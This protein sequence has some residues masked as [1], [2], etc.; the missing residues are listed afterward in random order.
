[1]PPFLYNGENMLSESEFKK[2]GTVVE[3]L[4]FVKDMHERNIMIKCIFDDDDDFKLHE[5]NSYLLIGYSGTIVSWDSVRPNNFESGFTVEVEFLNG[6][7]FTFLPEELKLSETPSQEL[8][9]MYEWSKSVYKCLSEPEQQT[10]KEFLNSILCSGR[11][12]DDDHNDLVH[13]SICLSM[14]FHKNIKLAWLREGE[15]SFVTKTKK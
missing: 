14:N 2:L 6:E 4:P 3:V 8:P 5:H 1:M 9:V 12:H 10:A 7:T 15:K 11:V 13:E